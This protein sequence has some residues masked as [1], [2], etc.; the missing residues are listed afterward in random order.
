MPEETT[1]LRQIPRIKID[2]PNAI[3]ITATWI[4]PPNNLTE[5]QRQWF[6]DM[7][8]STGSTYANDDSYIARRFNV[9]SQGI[10]RPTEIGSPTAGQI[11]PTQGAF[12]RRFVEVC[13][14]RHSNLL[15]CTTES[16]GCD[17]IRIDLER[18]TSKPSTHR[19]IEDALCCPTNVCVDITTMR[20]RIQEKR[21]ELRACATVSHCY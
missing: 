7:L 16:K 5:N 4:K 19:F 14:G 2:D 8:F 17:C 3:F 13:C 20:R 6:D 9:R 10:R 1:L 21:M 12:D 18:D 15:K 11:L